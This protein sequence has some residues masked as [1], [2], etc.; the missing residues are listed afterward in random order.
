MSIE[1]EVCELVKIPD[2]E[3]PAKCEKCIQERNGLE[4][5]ME[6]LMSCGSDNK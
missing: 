4:K 3:I 6:M 2:Y 5:T 1:C